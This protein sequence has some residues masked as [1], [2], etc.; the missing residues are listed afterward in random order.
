VRHRSSPGLMTLMARRS[1]PE[2]G[3]WSFRPSAFR[4]DIFPVGT[5]RPSVMRCGR[6]LLVVT[7]HCCCCHGSRIHIQP[8][9]LIS[10]DLCSKTG[11][12]MLLAN[13]NRASAREPGT[14]VPTCPLDL[15]Y[16]GGIITGL[17]TASTRPPHVLHTVGAMLKA[18]SLGT[19]GHETVICVTVCMSGSP[20]RRP[21][22]LRGANDE[23]TH[24]RAHQD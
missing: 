5:N 23:R 21:K 3:R 1:W 19:R 8:Y 22:R 20:M 12:C 7:G 16:E 13:H 4:P 24:H 10:G 11:D 9:A 15:I 17:H 14:Y 18:I 6:S 2:P